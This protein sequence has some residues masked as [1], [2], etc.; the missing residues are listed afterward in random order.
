MG[1]MNG[2]ERKGSPVL[3]N[4]IVRLRQEK[5]WSQAQLAVRANIG[6]STLF[7]AENSEAGVSYSKL[8][9]IARAL[10]VATSVIY[11]EAP[12]DEPVVRSEIPGWALQQ[13]EQVMTALEEIQMMLKYLEN[14]KRMT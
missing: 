9:K 10:D 8:V 7:R 3:G 4:E 2:I 11:R 14:Q 6:T 13:H 12:T 1:D 5:G